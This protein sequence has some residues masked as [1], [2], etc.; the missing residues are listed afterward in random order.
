MATNFFLQ[1][2]GIKGGC[3]ED[4]HKD[5]IAVESFSWSGSNMGSSHE[6][7]GGGTG[8]VQCGDF[9]FSCTAD[10]DMTG[11]IKALTRGTH[12]DGTFEAIKQGDGGGWTYLKI[13]LKE[14]VVSA[15]SVNALANG[16]P[17]ESITLN[18][19]KIEIEFTE[20]NSTGGKGSATN[21]GWDQKANKAL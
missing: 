9:S 1:L 8:R 13:Q 7:G 3:K 11:L 17:N 2:T 12:L 18:Y 16:L 10:T 15:Y 21:A 19:S 14:A 4:K 6:G 5:W 20:Q